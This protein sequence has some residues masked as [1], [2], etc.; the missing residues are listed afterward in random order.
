VQCGT[1]RKCE[2][3]AFTL[4]TTE[5]HTAAVKTD[6]YLSDS[7]GSPALGLAELR[8]GQVAVVT[9][10]VESTAL[11]AG[12]D[13]SHSLLTRLRDLGF[14]P[15]A[16]CEVVARMWLG[17]DPL[18]VRIGGSTFA[19]RRTEAA[20]VRVQIASQAAAAQVSPARE[21]SGAVAA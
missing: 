8:P 4:T 13:A 11:A 18:A 7:T 16:R 5:P 6:A 2:L 14:V 15:G 21:G 19:L 17:G 3:V 20:A 1:R 12:R 10:L 9:G